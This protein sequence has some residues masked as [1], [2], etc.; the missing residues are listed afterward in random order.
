LRQRALAA[1]ALV[2]A[3]SISC[4]A[5]A[6]KAPPVPPA[7]STQPT[8]ITQYWSTARTRV[9]VSGVAD[10]GALARVRGSFGYGKPHWTWGGIEAEAVSTSEV[11]F[12]VVR[13]RLALLIA[14]LA[15]AYRHTWSYR[16]SFLTRE[17]R[18]EDADLRTGPLARYHSLDMWLWGVI[19][20][21]SGYVD[22]EFEALRVYVPSGVD[23]YEEW[24]RTPLR[25]PWG[26]V[27]R[28]GYVHMFFDQRVSAGAIGEWV[29]PGPT[30]SVYRVG[31]LLSYAFGPHWDF[32]LL[33][34]AVVYGPDEL[35]FFNGLWGTARFRFKFASGEPALA[36]H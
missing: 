30:G 3:A 26:T 22:W 12:G 17:Q 23:V 36:H 1:L 34:T 10:L 8:S 32:T 35:S 27:C 11:G 6:Q 7:A 4:R 5:A 18:Y 21:G 9:F 24:L 29:W 33:L 16:R 20:A 19:P 28:L 13:A 14:D 15:I 31:P 2:C 25:P